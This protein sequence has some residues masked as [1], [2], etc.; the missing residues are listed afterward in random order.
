MID[1]TTAAAAV[2]IV[3][4]VDV[5]GV[6]VAVVDPVAVAPVVVAAAIVSRARSSL[7]RASALSELAAPLAHAANALTAGCGVPDR[8]WP[9]I[10]AA[11]AER[12][13]RAQIAAPAAA[14]ATVERS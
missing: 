10:A 11:P 8:R 12:S 9:A 14:S 2:P 3:V 4:D 7:A 5:A 1:P 13:A 6:D